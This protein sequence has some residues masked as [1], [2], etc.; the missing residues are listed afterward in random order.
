MFNFVMTNSSNLGPHAS[1]ALKYEGKARD[2]NLTEGKDK[3]RPNAAKYFKLAAES[4]IQNAKFA[5]YESS[6]KSARSNLKKAMKRMG[7][8]DVRG[9]VKLQGELDSLGDLEKRLTGEGQSKRNIVLNKTLVAPILSIV[10]FSF[11]LLFSPF[12]ISGFIIRNNV[13]PLFSYISLTCF[14]VGI[15]LAVVSLKSFIKRRKEF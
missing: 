8:E 12:N 7:D 10:A 3:Y 4:W 2:Y 13:L 14:S 5:N 11:A 15:V 6:I 9:R 1:V